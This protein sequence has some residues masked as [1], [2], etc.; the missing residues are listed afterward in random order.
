M[1]NY[2]PNTAAVLCRALIPQPCAPQADAL[3]TELPTPVL[4]KGTWRDLKE[5]V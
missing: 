1:L 3:P 5:L 2:I 4:C